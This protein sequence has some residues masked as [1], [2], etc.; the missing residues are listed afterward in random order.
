MLD[1]FA[2]DYRKYKLDVNDYLTPLYNG[3]HT[4]RGNFFTDYLTPL[5]NGH[6]TPRGNFFTAW[7]IKDAVVKWLNPKP[8]PY[9]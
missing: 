1:A 7:A 5:Y 3:H 4:P 6:H 9:R 8:L 2:A